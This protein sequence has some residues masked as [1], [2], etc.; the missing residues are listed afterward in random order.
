[1]I[2]LT[3]DLKRLS[4][5]EAEVMQVIWS[6]SAPVTVQQVL[7]VFAQ[8]RG[9][10]TSTLSTILSRLIEK[11]FLSKT[12]QG[13]TNFYSPITTEEQYKAHETQALLKDIHH[14]SVKSFFA[15]LVDSGISK[16]EIVELRKWF[17]QMEGDS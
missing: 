13:K 8:D 12:M 16:H 7:D 2:K 6:V 14:G 9:W 4:D 10:K 17:N 15:A 1:M 11:G 3:T 5:A